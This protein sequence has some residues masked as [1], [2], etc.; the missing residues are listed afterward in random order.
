M[1]KSA[2]HFL[3]A[4]SHSI[5]HLA[6]PLF[7]RFYEDQRTKFHPLRGTSLR[8]APR[9]SRQG[10]PEKSEK[11]RRNRVKGSQRSPRSKKKHRGSDPPELQRSRPHRSP[12]EGSQKQQKMP[13]RCIRKRKRSSPERPLQKLPER[14]Q[15]TTQRGPQI[16]AKE[17]LFED[18]WKCQNVW[19]SIGGSFSNTSIPALFIFCIFKASNRAFSFIIPP[20][21]VFTTTAV[22]FIFLN[23]S[24]SIKSF[25]FSFKGR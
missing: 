23:S 16:D 1:R 14:A 8:S 6:L 5:A 4:S 21:E 15:R 11:Q 12:K 22:F 25:V 9:S 18:P 3:K 10:F 20:L 24:L 17:A 2:C 13:Q 7:M 19:F